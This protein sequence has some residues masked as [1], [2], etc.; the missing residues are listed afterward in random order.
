MNQVPFVWEDGSVN[1]YYIEMFMGVGRSDQKRDSEWYWTMEEETTE[2]HRQ[3]GEIRCPGADTW[4]V[5]MQIP[6]SFHNC[7]REHPL[8]LGKEWVERLAALVRDKVHIDIHPAV[9]P[10]S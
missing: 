4:L 10:S 7:L 6:K 1:K 8:R 3:W 9:A 5:R 2:L